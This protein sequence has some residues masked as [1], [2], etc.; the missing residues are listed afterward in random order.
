L[1][2][3]LILLLASCATNPVTGRREISLVSESQEIAMGQ[4]ADPVITIQMGG[5][6]PDSAIQRYARGIAMPMATS[7][8]RPNLPW[9]FKV[10][11]DDLINA[12]AVPGGFIYVT[13]GILAHMNSEAELAGVLG[14][15]IGH[16]T[17]RHSATQMTRAQLAQIGLGVGMIFSET[18][19]GVGEA[20]AAGLQLL[21][22]RFGRDDERQADELGFRYMTQARYDPNAMTAVM[23]MLDNMTPVDGSGGVPNWLSTHP[24]PGDRAEANVARIAAAGTDFSGYTVD[25]DEFIQRLDDMV[26]GEDPRQGYFIGQRFFQPTLAFELTFPTGWAVQNSPLAVQSMS[27]SQDAAMSLSFAQANSA[28]EAANAFASMEGVT[29]VGSRNESPNG[30]ATR[31]LEFRAQTQQGELAGIVAFI[32]FDGSV[33]QI[34]GYGTTQGWASHQ[35]GLLNGLRS[36]RRLTDQR[37][38]DVEPHRMDIVRLP[39]AMSFSEFMQR[40][41]S[42]VPAEQIARINQVAAGDRLA[43]GRLMKRV[44]GGRVPTQ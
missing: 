7:S 15:E 21:F 25:H 39:A 35:T 42:S 8:E 10:L 26:F 40:Y 27:P 4:Q 14:H 1:R 16:V 17:A 43:S 19:R 34:L 9:S 24:D 38:T 23:R 28:A 29:V 41:P 11:D 18:I 2:N 20:A 37:Y 6:Y 33:Y 5:L 31:L 3:G 36:F 44:Q 32:D 12:F 30:I 22:L 13:R